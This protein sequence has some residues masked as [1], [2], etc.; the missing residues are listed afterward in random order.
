MTTTT[1]E[2]WGIV[3]MAPRMRPCLH[4]GEPTFRTS[5]IGFHGDGESAPFT[6]ERAECDWCAREMELL[7]A[8][9]A[10][11]PCEFCSAPSD[12]HGPCCPGQEALQ[13]LLAVDDE[14]RVF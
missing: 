8:A 14:D 10:A 13:A 6:I 2:T 1:T 9:M 12:T 5:V 3:R 4:C 7:D 11:L